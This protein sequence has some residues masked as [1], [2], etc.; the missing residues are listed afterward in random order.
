MDEASP[1]HYWVH[2]V[3]TN[4]AAQQLASRLQLDL[5]HGNMKGFKSGLK[6]PMRRLVISGED[7]PANYAL[8]FGPNWEQGETI[9]EIHQAERIE[10]LLAPPSAAPAG[11]MAGFMDEGYT[12]PWRPRPPT[13]EE[14]E[15]IGQVHHMSRVMGL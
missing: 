6:Y 11:I 13:K 15:K 2:T 8:L 12:G 5:P 3:H 4:P 9:K 1:W 7:N 10:M 14:E